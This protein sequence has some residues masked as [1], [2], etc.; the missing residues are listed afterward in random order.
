MRK[1]WLRWIKN[2]IKKILYYK[3]ILILKKIEIKK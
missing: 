2:K 3:E 1:I